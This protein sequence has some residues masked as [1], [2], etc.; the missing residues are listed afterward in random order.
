MVPTAE[1]SA[2]GLA[3]KN[4]GDKYELHSIEQDRRAN[5]ENRL[6]F[7]GKRI[8]QIL[9]AHL[10]GDPTSVEGLKDAV[11]QWQKWQTE[12]PDEDSRSEHFGFD[13][14]SVMRKAFLAG[15]VDRLCIKILESKSTPYAIDNNVLGSQLSLLWNLRNKYGV[16]SAQMPVLRLLAT[17]KP[18]AKWY[19]N[20]EWE[21]LERLFEFVEIAFPEVSPALVAEELIL[22]MWQRTATRQTIAYLK[23]K[24]RTEEDSPK[25]AAKIDVVCGGGKTVCAWAIL[26]AAEWAPVKIFVVHKPSMATQLQ[27]EIRRFG[28]HAIDLTCRHG[29]G[30]VP[31]TSAHDKEMEDAEAPKQCA[32]IIKGL[33]AQLARATKTSP[34]YL[35]LC[36]YTLRYLTST[37]QTPKSIWSNLVETLP[38]ETQVLMVVDE[39]HKVHKSKDIFDALLADPYRCRVVFMTGTEYAPKVYEEAIGVTNTDILK[40]A[41]TTG[42]MTLDEGIKLRYLVPAHVETVFATDAEERERNSA[43]ATPAQMVETA[44]TWMVAR[45]VR[46]A[47]VYCSTIDESKT[48]AADLEVELEKASR[49]HCTVWTRAVHSDNTITRNDAILEEF[50]KPTGPGVPDYR[51]VTSVAMLEEGFDFPELDA[52]ILFAVPKV[53]GRL[54]QIIQRC[55]RNTDGKTLG[56]ILLFGDDRVSTRV[57]KLLKKYDPT[58]AAISFGATPSTMQGHADVWTN[59]GGARDRCMEK[60][61]E[62]KQKLNV[63]LAGF[64]TREESIVAKLDGFWTFI[65]SHPAYDGTPST[66]LFDYCKAVDDQ[67]FE[68]TLN[69]GTVSMHAYHF[70]QNMRAAFH[71]EDHTYYL[72][73]EHLRRWARALPFWGADPEVESTRKTPMQWLE[74]YKGWWANDADRKP[75]SRGSKDAKEIALANWAPKAFPP[76]NRDTTQNRSLKAALGDDGYAAAQTFYLKH[77]SRQTAAENA[78]L[79]KAHFASTGKLPSRK[80][81][82]PEEKRLGQ[83]LANVGTPSS[84]PLKIEGFGGAEHGGAEKLDAFLLWLA[85]AKKKARGPSAAATASTDAPH[86]DGEA[87]EEEEESEETMEVE[88]EEESDDEEAI[89]CGVKRARE[90]ECAELELDSE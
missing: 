76:H 43:D 45:S 24:E 78:D 65:A 74:E 49:G 70:Y 79:V 44:A 90:D 31:A 85:E 82:D 50:R 47:V 58:R 10:Q 60:A 29:G 23:P 48:I 33:K 67:K 84:R 38:E 86:S 80:S 73:T 34:V 39:W 46:T 83:F 14:L 27:A 61:N 55:M 22:R 52:C 8:P 35:I 9:L 41:K 57:A 87:E 18:T 72:H 1:A 62:F 30:T 59:S 69:G 4:R 6:T 66:N 51:V 89:L 54:M 16:D 42:W 26:Q 68:Y 17:H 13:G 12:R 88:S 15:D 2:Q 56:Y 63:K 64:A 21:T 77:K 20:F 32:R 53:G 75:P 25:C 3:Y 36:Q 40:N 28:E 5:S 81:K 7:S 37:K 71:D 19:K 11:E